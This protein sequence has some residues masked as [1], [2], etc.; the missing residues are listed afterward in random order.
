MKYHLKNG[1]NTYQ[2]VVLNNNLV[3]EHFERIEEKFKCKYCLKKS[4][5][6]YGFK[7]IC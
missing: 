1:C 4:Y 5:N 2:N 3:K 7:G 6:Y